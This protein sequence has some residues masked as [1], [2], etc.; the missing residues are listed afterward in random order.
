MNELMESRL[1]AALCR[2]PAQAIFQLRAS[3]SLTVLAYHGIQDAD[4]FER[5]LDYLRHTHRPV[6]I[7]EIINALDRRTGLPRRSVLVTFD[8][9]DRSVHDIG[10]PLLQDRGI[11]AVAFVVG[12]LVDSE[13]PFWWEEVEDLVESG[14]TTAAVSQAAPDEVVKALK[15]VTN[16]Q[17]LAAIHD[18]RQVSDRVPRRRA[19]LTGRELLSLERAGIAVGNH[20]LTHPCLPRCSDLEVTR[21]VSETHEVLTRALGREPIA[22]AYPNGDWDGRAAALLRDLDYKAAFTFD[23]RL[24]HWPP[25]DAL[26]ISR[27]RVDAHTSLD[28]FRAIVSGLHPAI[29][30]LRGRL[31]VATEGRAR[32]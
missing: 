20:T 14:A 21:E 26:R 6:A 16:S 27:V 11:P 28:R 5:Q 19:H 7:D 3:R 4:M 22:F 29:H 18:M 15:R 24:S 25:R 31:R 8:D 13:E 2:S 10:L 32:A 9:G 1:D 23:H 12:G 17:R 30:R